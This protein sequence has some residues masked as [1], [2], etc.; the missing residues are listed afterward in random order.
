MLNFRMAFAQVLMEVPLL[1]EFPGEETLIHA[2]YD[3]ERFLIE[4]KELFQTLGF[5]VEQGE[6]QFRAVDAHHRHQFT[7]VGP[8]RPDA[9]RIYVADVV[10]RFG[11]DLYF[12]RSRL[13]LRASSA[14]TTLNLRSLR[15]RLSNWVEVPG[16]HLFGQ[17][18][19][20][21]GWLDRGLATG[22]SFTGG[23]TLGPIDGQC[24]IWYD[25]GKSPSPPHCMEVSHHLVRESMVKP[26]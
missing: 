8:P 6:N 9:C 1:L 23:S 5:T 13:E 24:I 22:E 20:L 16:P 18:R 12:D 4:G 7:C 2:W 25:R 15:S 11:S 3:G 19:K 21:W 10:Q 17:T 26:D 14:A